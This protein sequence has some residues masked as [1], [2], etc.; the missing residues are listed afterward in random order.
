MNI[1][2]PQLD[3]PLESISSGELSP[4]EMLSQERTRQGVS[5]STVA[6]ALKIT[7]SYIKALDQNDFDHLPEPAFIRGYLR[8]YARSIGL[9]PEE[10]VACFDR[11]IGENGAEAPYLKAGSDQPIKSRSHFSPAGFGLTLAAA[12][13]VGGLTYFGWNVYR[14]DSVPVVAEVP[15]QVVPDES[16]ISQSP[17]AVETLGQDFIPAPELDEMEELAGGDSEPLESPEGEF[18]ADPELIDPPVPSTVSSATTEEV[19]V[20]PKAIE[21]EPQLEKPVQNA[22]QDGEVQLAIRFSEDCWIEVRDAKGGVMVSDLKRAGTQLDL[23][24][25]AP[26]KIRLGNAPGVSEMT[27]D[28]VPVEISSGK[29]VASLLL[30]SAKQG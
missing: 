13:F 28:G 26:V 9:K 25:L 2:N 12:V 23:N 17:I 22:L 10:V 7:E 1:D 16:A 19:V 24:V 14:S 29:R 15:V 11:Y 5:I 3:E 18:V 4:G 27:F 6:E 21:A 30:E 8:N 20:E